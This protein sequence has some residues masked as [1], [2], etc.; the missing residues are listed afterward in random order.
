MSSDFLGQCAAFLRRSSELS[1][2]DISRWFDDHEEIGAPLGLD[3]QT[4]RSVV[5]YLLQK[6]LIQGTHG[7]Q[8]GITPAG[9]EAAHATPASA[10]ESRSFSNITISG[11]TV[12]FGDGASI[13]ITNVTLRDVLRHLEAEIASKVSDPEQKKTLLARLRD[14]VGHPAFASILQLGLPELLKR[15]Q[16]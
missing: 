5:I 15:L 7:P 8:V 2:G 1:N 4:T 11:S 13:N 16:E 6:K 9:I 10:R 3:P 14:L 12:N